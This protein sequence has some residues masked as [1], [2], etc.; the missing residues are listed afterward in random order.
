M[1]IEYQQTE[2]PEGSLLLKAVDKAIAAWVADRSKR[3]GKDWRLA[4]KRGTL[5]DKV[6]QERPEIVRKDIPLSEQ[7][8]LWRLEVV[9]RAVRQI[10]RREFSAEVYAEALYRYERGQMDDYVRSL[11]IPWSRQ[12]FVK[13]MG[14]I[15][16]WV[17]KMIERYPMPVYETECADD[18]IPEERQA[19]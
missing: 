8:R 7:Q 15:R 9:D 6:G 17:G 16:K 5:P 11:S 18:I 12:M 13:D 10:A 3:R 2:V 4:Y 19:A 14:Y 1:T